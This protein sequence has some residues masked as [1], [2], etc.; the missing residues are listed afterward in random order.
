MFCHTFSP[1]KKNLVQQLTLMK[2]VLMEKIWSDKNVLKAQGHN[3]MATTL[4]WCLYSVVKCCL[5]ISILFVYIYQD[6]IVQRDNPDRLPHMQ[7]ENSITTDMDSVAPYPDMCVSE[8]SVYFCVNFFVHSMNL[9]I[10]PVK[11]SFPFQL[12]LHAEPLHWWHV[13]LNSW[14][15]G[16]LI[17]HMCVRVWA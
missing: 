1:V 13:M 9:F 17:H 4:Q 11:L 15:G 16:G 10:R 3:T 6:N 2:E 5:R 14:V 7:T 8:Q 12:Q